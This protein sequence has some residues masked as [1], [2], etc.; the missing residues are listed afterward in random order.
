[1]LISVFLLETLITILVNPDEQLSIVRHDLSEG[2]F[3]QDRSETFRGRAATF[4]G[5][6]IVIATFL[7]SVQ[8]Q[9]IAVSSA[10]EFVWSTLGFLLLSYQLKALTNLNRFWVNMQEKTFEYGFLSLLGLILFLSV[11]YGNTTG[12]R[13][14][15]LGIVLIILFRFFA[16]YKLLRGLHSMWKRNNDQSRKGYFIS[17]VGQRF[18][19]LRDTKGS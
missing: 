6:T 4:V 18:H 14:L 12:A 10:M 19:E 5:F 8:N 16:V 11:P 17:L 9:T 13:F 15:Q 3:T 2:Q 1:M 7:L